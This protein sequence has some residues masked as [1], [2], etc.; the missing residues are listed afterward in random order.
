ME[1]VSHVHKDQNSIHNRI[2]AFVMQF[3][4]TQAAMQTTAI[5]AG[6][7]KRF[8][9]LKCALSAMLELSSTPINAYVTR[10]RVMQGITQIC[11]KIVGVWLTYQFKGNVC[12]AQPEPISKRL[13]VCAMNYKDSWVTI[14]INV[15]TAGEI[16]S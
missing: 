14:Q 9:N 2:H 15:R 6:E 1:D 5:T 16:T 11:V 8:Q 4:V 7:N 13:N 12:P 3:K 10:Q